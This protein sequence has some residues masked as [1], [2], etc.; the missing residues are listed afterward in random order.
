M[1]ALEWSDLYAL[2]NAETYSRLVDDVTSKGLEYRALSGFMHRRM[3]NTDPHI[4]NGVMRTV[5]RQ[6]FE[7]RV[8]E[9]HLMSKEAWMFN[10]KLHFMV[11]KGFRMHREEQAAQ[12]LAMKKAE[13]RM[14]CE[15]EIDALQAKHDASLIL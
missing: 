2:D 5:K 6:A 12:L 14:R 9:L 8:A 15:R 7:G 13:C 4:Y 10:H 1:K 11:V 3:E